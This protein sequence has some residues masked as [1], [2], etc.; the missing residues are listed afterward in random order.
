VSKF[1]CVIGY[2]AIK[3]ELLEICDM[4]KNPD[5]Y[6]KLGTT[7]PRGIMLHRGDL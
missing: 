6:K 1:D 5:I 2:Q 4:M 7:M 3:R